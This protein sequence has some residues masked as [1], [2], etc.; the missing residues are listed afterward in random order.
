MSWRLFCGVINTFDGFHGI[1]PSARH[2]AVIIELGNHPSERIDH[3][4]VLDMTLLSLQRH[5]DQ[6]AREHENNEL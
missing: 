6:V 2:P 1:R 5:L 3:Q 4:S